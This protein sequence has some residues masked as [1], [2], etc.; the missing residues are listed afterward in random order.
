VQQGLTQDSDRKQDPFDEFMKSDEKS[1]ED[2][3]DDEQVN[4]LPCL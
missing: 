2:A 3:S 1:E 4:L